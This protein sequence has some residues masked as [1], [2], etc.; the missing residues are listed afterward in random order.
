MLGMELDCWL[1]IDFFTLKTEYLRLNST[2]KVSLVNA[3][4][5]E[6]TRLQRQKSVRISEVQKIFLSTFFQTTISDEYFYRICK[7][8]SLLAHFFLRCP[9]CPIRRCRCPSSSCPCH[10]PAGGNGSET[11]EILRNNIMGERVGCP[12]RPCPEGCLSTA[13]GNTVWE[14]EPQKERCWRQE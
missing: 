4:K 8:Y 3:V 1:T 10:C 11:W 13:V 12:E 9:R 14:D 6:L 2:H 7:F 5:I